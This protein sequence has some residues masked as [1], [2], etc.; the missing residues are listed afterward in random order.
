LATEGSGGRALKPPPRSFRL[1]VLA[2]RMTVGKVIAG[3]RNKYV[4][5]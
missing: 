3:I 1:A 2:L 5:I 4:F